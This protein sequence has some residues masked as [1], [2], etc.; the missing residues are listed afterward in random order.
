PESR[1]TEAFEDWGKREAGGSLDAVIEIN[2]A[3]GELA[4]QERADGGFAGTHKAS[5]AQDRY[6]GLRPAERRC[7]GH[8]DGSAKTSRASECELYHCRRR[9]R[10]CRGPIRRCQRAP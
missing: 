1:F 7:S 8:A 4:G 10:L 2:K 9:A 5:Q 6:A 3:P